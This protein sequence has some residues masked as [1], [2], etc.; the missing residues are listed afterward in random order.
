ID[1]DRITL[2]SYR[3]AFQLE[4]RLH[5][6]DRF[7]IPVPYGIPLAALGY[8]A[9]VGLV[10]VIASGLPMTRAVVGLVPW[11]L[12]LILIPAL[13]AHLLCRTGSDGRPAH[14][15]LVARLVFLVRP[16]R[17]VALAASSRCTTARLD[18][19]ALVG[20]EICATYRKGDVRGPA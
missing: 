18:D 12:R 17:L 11:P 3:L 20:D 8:G 6:I 19:I 13:G 7:R 16:R 10:A 2:R 9:V 15:A 14:E 5:R 1:D 4:R